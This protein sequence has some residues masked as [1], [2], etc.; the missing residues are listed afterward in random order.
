MIDELA[1]WNR[2]LSSAEVAA[3]YQQGQNGLTIPVAQSTSPSIDMQNSQWLYVFNVDAGLGGGV[4]QE[5][6]LADDIQDVPAAQRLDDTAA[7]LDDTAGHVDGPFHAEA[8][9]PKFQIP[10]KPGLRNIS[11]GDFTV[12]TR[13]RTTDAAR[14]VL[15]GNYTD[16]ALSTLNLEL[17]DQNRVR[18][19]FRKPPALPMDMQISAGSVNTRDGAWHHLAG[20]RKGSTLY[21]YLDGQE[22][23]QRSDT[24]GSFTLDD[25]D[26]FLKG[27]ARNDVTVFDGDMEDAR[28]W[29][30]ALSTNELAA[31]TIGDEPG[32]GTVAT[33]NMLAQYTGM[34]GPHDA[35][36]AS[37]RHRI[38]LVKPLTLM[39][40][41]NFT[42]E[43]WF[44]STSTDRGVL[45]G[46]YPNNQ[47]Y[48]ALNLEVSSDRKCRL[49][50]QP[51]TTGYP[52]Y[53]LYSPANQNIRDGQWHHMAGVRRDGSLYIYLDGQQIAAVTDPT[54][55]FDL[56]APYMYVGRDA[57]TGVTEYDGDLREVRMW[58]RALT[59][60][61][62]SSIYAGKKP[63]DPEVA[64]DGMLTEH[65]TIYPAWTNTLAEAGYDG[66]RFMRS[67]MEI[68][69]K[70][71]FVFEN[72]PRHKEI[73]LG[74]LLAQL[75]SLDPV[76]G[77]DHFS[78]LVDGVEVMK[79]GLGFDGDE[80]PQVDTLTLLGESADVQLMK[81]ALV[82]GGENLFY[83]GSGTEDYNEHVYDL[84]LLEALQAI[85]HTSDT[86]LLE[87]IG[88]QDADGSAESFGVDQVEVSFVPYE[89][90]IILVQ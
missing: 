72:L 78:I 25:T 48:S 12:E 32:N 41:T 89:G 39:T 38:K 85:P 7:R 42:V 84:S 24:A 30:R 27:D 44:R 6:W 1:L 22:V 15:I 23:G 37:P 65:T 26:Y 70:L 8:I 66:S 29:T 67:Y 14:G 9:D 80:E 61:E 90:T 21:V 63:G 31:L 18:L 60:S 83:C 2:A 73:A 34:Y 45:L 52:N 56:T 51:H 57:R 77:G 50:I 76:R 33:S 10:I 58:S 28:F 64:I 40:R 43:T 4:Y 47:N 17:L 54:C 69:N 46:S 20:M 11:Q 19:Y 87:L 3:L 88:K 59:V 75:D 71:S 68:S 16:P 82:L 35:L 74:G 49:Y 55:S 53:S 36:Y 62:I 81:D 86:L 79:V 5:G 13:F